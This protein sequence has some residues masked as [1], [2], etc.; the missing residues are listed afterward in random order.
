MKT[1]SDVNVYS[2]PETT[3]I[4]GSY[5]VLHFYTYTSSSSISG[6]VALDVT[7]ACIV[8]NLCPYDAREYVALSKDA[9]GYNGYYTVTLLSTDTEELSGKYIQKPELLND[10]KYDYR[11]GRG[12]I[13]I[14]P[15]GGG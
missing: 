13:N 11:L 8:W 14:I 4:G 2:F 12:I 3:F 1:F 9:V 5:K 6:S 10:G 7:S 15:A